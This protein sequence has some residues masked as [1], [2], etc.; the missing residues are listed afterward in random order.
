MNNR[1][2]FFES[3]LSEMP[4]NLGNIELF[5][6]IEY[7]IKERSKLTKPHDLGEGYKKISGTQTLYYW[8]ESNGEIFIGIE[9]AVKQQTLIVNAVAKNPSYKNKPPYAT[10]LYK[11]VLDDNSSIRVMSDIYLTNNSI[12]V[13]KRLINSG[14]TVSV[15]DS[16]KPG[17]NFKKINS[18]EELEK[19][20]GYDDRDYQRYQFVLTSKDEILAEVTSIF[21]TRRL[22]ELSGLL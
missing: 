7:N 10:D 13:W 22:R 4:E 9:L 19:Y 3:W 18:I 8:Y 2:D 5:D 16:E 6:M 21:N 12:N 20:I 17:Q 15:Y 1:L 14:V 11:K